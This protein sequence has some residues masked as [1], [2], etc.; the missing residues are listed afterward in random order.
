LSSRNFEA[1]LATFVQRVL[2]RTRAQAETTSLHPDQRRLLGETL[3]RFA[4]HCEPSDP[5]QPLGLLYL[6][7]RAAGRKAD[8]RAEHVATFCLL[9]L[10]SLDLFDDMQDDDLA[11]KPHAS[12]GPAIAVNSAIALLFLAFDSLRT[13]IE[14]EEDVLIKQRYHATFNRISLTTV[15]CQHADLLGE[16]AASTPE[17]VLAVHRGKTSSVALFL[18][19]GA[20][21]AGFGPEHVAAYGR[22]GESLACLIQIVDDV[23]DIYGK[24]FS[25]DLAGRKVTYPL[26]CFRQTASSSQRLELS[27][28]L[29]SEPVPL[30]EV[31]RL[32]HE[33]TAIDQCA[34]DLERIRVTIH[35]EIA[36]LATLAPEQRIL[37]GIVDAVAGAIYEVEPLSE[38]AALWQPRGGFHDHVREAARAFHAELAQ[39][40]APPV[41]RLEPWHQPFCLFEPELGVIRYPDVEGLPSEVLPFHAQLWGVSDQEAARL[42][43]TIAPTLIAHEMFHVWRHELGLLTEDAWHEEYVANR[44]AVAFAKRYRTAELDLVAALATRVVSDQSELLD[45][46]AHATLRRSKVASRHERYGVSLPTAAVMHWQM[47][48][49]LIGEGP[50]L[51]AEIDRFLSVRD[52][53]TA[54]E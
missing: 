11:G 40:G 22:I 52:Q 30:A 24:D 5:A 54:A 34:T 39:V 3:D 33:S 7:F 29:S 23:R 32:L 31:R 1:G 37:L 15:G 42:W 21:L 6:V 28:L 47:V 43:W 49:E 35:R 45:E 10:C 2:S 19:C 46:Q 4:A 9:Y 41:P 44:L 8:E 20:L 26:A 48:H 25:P 50:D 17:E 51:E 12:A 14:L 16:S 53:V 18:E 13:A 27:K 36:S 38:T